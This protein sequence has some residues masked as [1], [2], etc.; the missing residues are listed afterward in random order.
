VLSS[1]PKEARERLVAEPEAGALRFDI[2]MQGEQAT[3][4][5]AVARSSE[6]RYG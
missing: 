1:V 4:F 3:V 2:H 5:F 6:V